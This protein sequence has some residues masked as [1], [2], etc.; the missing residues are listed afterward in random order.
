MHPIPEPP[1]G[2]SGR[3][4]V[5]PRSRPT[6]RRRRSRRLSRMAHLFAGTAADRVRLRTSSLVVAIDLGF[7]ER[8]E[9]CGIAWRDAHGTEHERGLSFGGCVTEVA[10]L[11]R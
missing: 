3:C 7:A 5:S 10:Q 9:S 6:R 1:A 11:V 2:K 4:A 8:A